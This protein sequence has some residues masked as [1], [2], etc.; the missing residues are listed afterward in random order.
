MNDITIRTARQDDIEKINEITNYSILNSSYNLN[1]HTM[2]LRDTIQWFEN[3]IKT[4]Y[5][6]IVAESNNII[7]GWASLSK[8]REFSGYKTTAECSVYVKNE[9]KRKGIGFKLLSN[10]EEKA[11]KMNIHVLVAV[12]T[13]NNTASITLHKK[14][15]FVTK[16]ILEQIA[17]KNGKFFDVKIMTKIIK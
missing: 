14:A 8:F 15:G 1:T 9:F 11:E 5:P 4:K 17:Y 13:Y 10:L 6:I 2:S 3:H 16:G 7:V 12:I